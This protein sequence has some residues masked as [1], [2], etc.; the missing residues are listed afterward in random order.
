MQEEINPNK[1]DLCHKCLMDRPGTHKERSPTFSHSFTIHSLTLVCRDFQ[2]SRTHIH[3]ELSCQW[4]HRGIGCVA[5]LDQSD[6]FESCSWST[7]LIFES[8]ALLD[9]SSTG[10]DITM[11][12]SFWKT[13]FFFSSFFPL[14]LFTP[15]AV[16]LLKLT[17][18]VAFSWDILWNVNKTRMG[19]V[20]NFL[21]LY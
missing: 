17:M 8:L 12:C 9:E 21:N 5:A 13:I 19:W 10:T 2:Q 6:W 15:Y 7:L 11:C 3:N 16:F 20:I 4:R 14:H 1:L 18:L